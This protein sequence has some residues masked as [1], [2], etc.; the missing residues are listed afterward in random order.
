MA[1]RVAGCQAS[2][3]SWIKTA[4]NFSFGEVTRSC[5]AQSIDS[6]GGIMSRMIGAKKQEARP[7]TKPSPAAR[8]QG[9]LGFHTYRSFY[10]LAWC[11]CL[12][13]LS[14]QRR[15]CGRLLWDAREA[16][17]THPPS[18]QLRTAALRVSTLR[19]ASQ[20]ASDVHVKAH[21]EDG[22]LGLLRR[23][24]AS[25]PARQIRRHCGNPNAH[26]LHAQAA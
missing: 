18:S 19:P 5:S 21:A 25:R 6:S 16:C 20:S 13:F 1:R 12:I 17:M 24:D 23:Q 11:N 7:A 15:I 14:A 10:A 9:D 2:S 4:S 26:H 22:G 8:S 3:P